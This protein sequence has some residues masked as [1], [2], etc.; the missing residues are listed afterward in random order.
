[1]KLSTEP[2]THEHWTCAGPVS[3]FWIVPLSVG[4][5]SFDGWW[6]KKT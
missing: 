4:E 5:L 6:E 3:Y 2:P 1:V